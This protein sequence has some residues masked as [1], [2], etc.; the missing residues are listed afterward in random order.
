MYMMY[1]S[2]PL[3]KDGDK[4]YL[5][6]ALGAVIPEYVEPKLAGF[7][8]NPPNPYSPGVLWSGLG[9]SE[10]ITA[11]AVVGGAIAGVAWFLKRKKK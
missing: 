1:P 8:D 9:L 6:P 4:Y 7:G 10:R 11:I 2:H 3:A 5:E